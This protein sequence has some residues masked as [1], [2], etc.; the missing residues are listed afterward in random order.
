MCGRLFTIDPARDQA[1]RSRFALRGNPKRAVRSI[2]THSVP[3]FTCRWSSDS[4]VN[5]F[6]RPLRC[7][8]LANTTENFLALSQLLGLVSQEVPLALQNRRLSDHALD[9][10]VRD[11]EGDHG[12]EDIVQAANDMSLD[13]LSG[14]VGDESLLLDLLGDKSGIGHR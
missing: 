2:S 8:T 6:D 4:P 11:V 1:A 5:C 13:D 9:L 12:R 10:G 3:I 14:D 7:S